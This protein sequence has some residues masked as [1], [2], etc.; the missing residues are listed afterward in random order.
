MAWL[1]N[2]RQLARRYERLAEHFTVFA[3][4]ASLLICHHRLHKITT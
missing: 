4:V 2:H 1:M 3:T